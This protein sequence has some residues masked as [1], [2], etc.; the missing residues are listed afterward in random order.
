MLNDNDEMR[1]FESLLENF[2]VDSFIEKCE[3]STSLVEDIRPETTL[4][5]DK[6]SIE[7]ASDPDEGKV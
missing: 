1:E 3:P 6:V 5:V 4:A 2:D 7:V